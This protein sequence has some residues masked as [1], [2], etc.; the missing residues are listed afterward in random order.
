VREARWIKG[1][2]RGTTRFGERPRFRE[3]LYRLTSRTY[4][5]MVPN[6]SWGETNFGLIDCDGESVLVDTG[7]DL[8]TTREFLASASEILAISP[9]GL[10]FNTHGDGDHCWGN[11][12]FHGVPVIAS[13]AA[14]RHMRQIKP[15]TLRLLAKACPIMKA[16]PV[17]GI[18]SLGHYVGA[19][20]APYDFKG[21]HLKR[22]DQSF[23]G[24]KT[25][26]V[27]GTE[28]VLTQVG[29][30]HSPGDAMIYVP[31]EKVLYAGDIAF[32]DATPV[33]WAGPVANIVAGLGKVLEFDAE[34]IIVGHGPIANRR[35]IELQIAYWQT[36]QEELH[37]RCRLGMAAA[38]AASDL[39]LSP[40]FQA[41]AFAQW[42]SPERLIRNA[43][44]LYQE[45]GL[46]PL[47][48]PTSLATLNTLRRQAL[49]ARKLPAATPRSL[50]QH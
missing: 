32:S 50:H 8:A 3:G 27:N 28:L 11:Q 2:D 47:P 23:S 20:L 49:L 44:A 4:A 36:I 43:E 41:T 7:W 14:I 48:L 5:W 40:T 21:I 17:G 37:K 24:E 16:L 33:M 46:G 29:P 35:D 15:A 19:M 13:D 25:I 31:S 39:L 30:A 22:P 6:G 1:P 18:A 9:I 45:W 26:A 38:D 42:D 12:L 10:V 34:F